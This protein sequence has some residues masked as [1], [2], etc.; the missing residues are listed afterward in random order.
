[1]N[2]ISVVGRLFVA[3]LLA[4]GF[5]A[6]SWEGGETYKVVAPGF[7]AD[8]AKELA[9]MFAP[10]SEDILVCHAHSTR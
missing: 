2:A 3:R 1:M 4:V 7:N 8:E 9:E 5:K 6:V 10:K